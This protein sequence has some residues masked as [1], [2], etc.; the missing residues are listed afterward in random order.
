MQYQQMFPFALVQLCSMLFFLYL[1]LEAGGGES[2][3][4]SVKLAVNWNL[5]LI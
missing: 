1:L 3:Q 2:L 5:S 4:A